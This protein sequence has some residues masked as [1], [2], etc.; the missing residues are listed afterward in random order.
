MSSIENEIQNSVLE[1]YED[2]LGTVWAKILPTLGT[3]TVVTI[4]QRAV[5]RTSKAHPILIHLDVSDSGLSFEKI[6]EHLGEADRD[7]LRN[8]FKDLIANLFDILAKLTG[9]II[10]KQLIKEVDGLALDADNPQ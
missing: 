5:N 6:R 1:I 4:V 9:N 10:V 3:V 2:L 8:S 7:E